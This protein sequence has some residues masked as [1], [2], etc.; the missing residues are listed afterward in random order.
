MT[1]HF[2]GAKLQGP[3][4]LEDRSQSLWARA[5]VTDLAEAKRAYEGQSW[6]VLNPGPQKVFHQIGKSYLI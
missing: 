1:G 2:G 6:T 5:A 3:K 4:G